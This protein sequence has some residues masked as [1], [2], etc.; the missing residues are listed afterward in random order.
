MSELRAALQ[1]YLALRR[2]LGYTL[3][4][5]GW[6]LSDFVGYLE[7]HRASHV[8]TELALAWATRPAGTH[9]RWWSKRLST[10]RGF[11]RH[12]AT[13]DPRNQV[14]P[15]DLLPAAYTRVTP[16]LYSDADITALLA[17]ARALSP[18][19]RAATYQTLIG[20]LAVSGLRIGEAIGLDQADVDDDALLLAVRKA[21]PGSA[22][23][24]PLH[25][26]TAGAL[27]GYARLRDHHFPEP[28]SPGFFVS[29]RGTRLAYSDA[30]KTFRE[31]IRRAGLEGR[32]ERRR[33]RA[34][35]LRHSF[36]VATVLRWYREGADVDARLPLLSA[37]LGHADPA[38][39][40]W[41]LQA[42]PELL[43]LVAQRLQQ[44]T[45]ELT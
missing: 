44:A 16:Y 3:K 15:A 31:L 27:R 8:T 34:H 21:K 4:E 5:A 39:T 45:G 14:P 40:Y 13:I 10:A 35:D 22:R 12:L 18:A 28:A 9:P 23:T 26:T 38:S 17:A 29:A 1:D 2:A 7:E 11:A 20:L 19:L 30:N 41:Y 43:A 36:A 33:P 32:G 25:E 37:M 6:L 24:V 42:A